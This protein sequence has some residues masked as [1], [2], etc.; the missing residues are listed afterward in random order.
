LERILLDEWILTLI[1][2]SQGYTASSR[3]VQDEVLNLD[4]EVCILLD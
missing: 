2:E 1:V 4:A 3:H